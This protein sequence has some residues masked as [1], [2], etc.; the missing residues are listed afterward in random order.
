M[1]SNF[2]LRTAKQKKGGCP[3]L[4]I[5]TGWERRRSGEGGVDEAGVGWEVILQGWRHLLFSSER[6]WKSREQKGVSGH[7]ALRREGRLEG[8]KR[9]GHKG[10]EDSGARKGW[11]YRSRLR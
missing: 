10:T 1:I 6:G 4:H 9:E 8:K 5:I 2:H 3:A 11:R 7:R